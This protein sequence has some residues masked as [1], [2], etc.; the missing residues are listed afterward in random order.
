LAPAKGGVHAMTNF[1]VRAIEASGFEAVLAFYPTYSATPALS[2]PSFRLLQRR[3]GHQLAF[4]AEGRE[5][6]AIG[7]WLPELEFTHYLPT[8]AWRELMD[9]CDAYMVVSGNALAATPF[10]LAGR[11]Y[12]A[13]IATDWA[14]DRRDR[15][16]AFPWPRRVL[17]ACVNSPVIRRLERALLRGGRVVALSA[18]TARAL[19]ACARTHVSAA[20][21]PVPVDVDLFTPRPAARVAGRLGFAGRFNDPRKNIALLLE[22]AAQLRRDGEDVHVVLMG[23]MPDATVRETVRACGLDNHVSFHAGLS[24]TQMRDLMQT[25]DVFVLASHQEGLCISAL[26]ALA[27]GVPVVST[28]CG[29]PE[30][31]VLAGVSGELVD[32]TPAAM[33][34]AQRRILRDAAL[35]DRLATGGRRLVEERYS[36]ARAN[37]I[38]REQLLLAFPVAGAD[39]QPGAAKAQPAMGA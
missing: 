17:D 12:L 32:S 30:E 3:P 15:V 27:C 4:D 10:H 24:R 36:P 37:A 25:L 13:W 14:G 6:H 20:Q 18:H 9:D 26:E 23:D 39:A 28:R 21:L 33:A 16:R 34:Q 19:D 8:R 22:A 7:A 31:F 2:V 35:R 11:P 29:G 5:L 38:L 1:A